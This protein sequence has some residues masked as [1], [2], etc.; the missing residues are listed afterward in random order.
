MAMMVRRT[1]PPTSKQTE[2]FS[3]DL[4]S[5]I[6]LGFKRA[7]SVHLNEQKAAAARGAWGL[8]RKKME[9]FKYEV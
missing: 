8:A 3:V 9:S 1:E 6:S 7:P 4:D 2:D 5:I